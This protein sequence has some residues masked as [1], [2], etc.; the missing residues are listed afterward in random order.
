M[1][2]I[3]MEPDKGSNQEDR[4]RKKKKRV[5]SFQQRGRLTGYSSCHK[6][7]NLTTRPVCF[8]CNLDIF[9]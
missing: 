4:E 8:K 5:Q 9:C 3:Q 6:K 7:R 2:T 1:D